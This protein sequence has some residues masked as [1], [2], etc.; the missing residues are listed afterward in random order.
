MK[1]FNI[2]IPKANFIDLHEDYEVLVNNKV[3]GIIYYT[4]EENKNGNFV[5]DFCKFEPDDAFSFTWDQTSAYYD[6]SDGIMEDLTVIFNA[7]ETLID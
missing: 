6:S 1:K 2:V 4:H 3:I 7:I 5:S